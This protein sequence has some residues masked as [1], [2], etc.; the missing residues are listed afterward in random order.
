RP[1]RLRIPRDPPVRGSARRPPLARAADLGR[2]DPLQRHVPPGRWLWSSDANRRQRGHHHM[3]IQIPETV[4][5]Q[6]LPLINPG[7]ASSIRVVS[8]GK[9]ARAHLPDIQ[10]ASSLLTEKIGVIEATGEVRLAQA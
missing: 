1:M 8:G 3:S 5:E 7:P 4:D 10:V 6:D 9:S 2:P